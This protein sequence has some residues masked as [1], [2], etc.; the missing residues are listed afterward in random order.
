MKPFGT[1]FIILYAT[2]SFLFASNAL[3]S[4]E[5]HEDINESVFA[6]INDELGN[7]IQFEEVNRQVQI[8]KNWEL[9]ERRRNASKTDDDMLEEAVQ[10]QMDRGMPEDMARRMLKREIKHGL[11]QPAIG[12]SF[13][14]IYE[15]FG[16]GSRGSGSS[17]DSYQWNFSN[18]RMSGRLKNSPNRIN[19]RLSDDS[20]GIELT[21]TEEEG[22]RLVFRVTF[23]EGI[24]EYNQKD[25][26]VRLAVIQNDEAFVL[27]ADNFE[28]LLEKHPAELRNTLLPIWESLGIRKP[29][30]FSDPAVVAA[31]IE[32]LEAI[33]RDGM[34]VVSFLEALA[35]DSLN[36]RDEAET[37][38]MNSYHK[39]AVLIE[40]H[41]VGMK[42]DERA[43]KRLERI[44]QA[45]PANPIQDYVNS[46]DFDNPDTLNRFLK[47][48][49]KEKHPL[50]RELLEN[51][52]SESTEEQAPVQEDDSSG[53]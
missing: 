30:S 25:S 31:A 17:G 2:I 7:L 3:V 35:G 32:K 5:L 42:F 14:K 18:N 51:L 46:Q 36:A 40:T 27:T 23:D 49:P 22:V 47:F 8:V 16:T 43:A 29:L 24:I 1:S 12:N 20:A 4:Q 10:K 39:W 6:E 53:Q 34:E 9:Q 45:S 41:E 11:Q 21:V 44:K 15:V 48:A 26:R 13:L 37:A 28:Q 52:E 19:L 50:I 38:L 33:E